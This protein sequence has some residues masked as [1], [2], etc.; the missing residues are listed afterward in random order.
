[1]TCSVY[2]SRWSGVM[3]IN[4]GKNAQLITLDHII[5]YIYNVDGTFLVCTQLSL[6]PIYSHLF[7]I[8]I[9]LVHIDTCIH[10]DIICIYIYIQYNVVQ[11]TQLGIL[12]IISA[13]NTRPPRYINTTC[14]T[15]PQPYT[16]ILG[17]YMIS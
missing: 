1:M 10:I 8:Y 14:H 12:P 4:N 2:I 17:I 13:H 16:Y 7:S 5:L 15:I 3:C 6:L 9:L 11:R